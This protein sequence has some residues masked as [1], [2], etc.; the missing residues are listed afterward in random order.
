MC[1]YNKQTVYEHLSIN[2]RYN[3]TRGRKGPVQSKLVIKVRPLQSQ[4][5]VLHYT[6]DD[7]YKRLTHT[8]RPDFGQN[9]RPTQKQTVQSTSL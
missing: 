4:K 9:L 5:T 7:E 2:G 6:F 1:D 8:Q 3:F